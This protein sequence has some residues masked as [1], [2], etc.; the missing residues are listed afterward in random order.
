MIIIHLLGYSS[1]ITLIM[2]IILLWLHVGWL[3]KNEGL[4]TA[5]AND[6]IEKNSGKKIGLIP[7]LF[8]YKS[9]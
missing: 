3:V 7:A 8:L 5:I 1:T 2:G 9:M 4:N 6:E